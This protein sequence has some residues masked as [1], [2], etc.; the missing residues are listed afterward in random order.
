MEEGG[1]EVEAAGHAA[2]EIFHRVAAT[3]GKLHG[4]ER[5]V[6]ARAEIGAAE[7]VEFAEDAEVLVGAELGVERDVLGDGL[8]L[9]DLGDNRVRIV[10]EN[11]KGGEKTYTRKYIE[12]LYSQ[13]R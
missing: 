6:D 12:K 11:G 4:L 2:G 3:V 8:R 9:H 13:T 5:L 1:D 7:A 10:D